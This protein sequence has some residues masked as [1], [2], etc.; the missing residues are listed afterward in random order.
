MHSMVLSSSRTIVQVGL[1]GES[2]QVPHF[3]PSTNSFT[4]EY[5]NN[6]TKSVLKSQSGETGKGQNPVLQ[7][8]EL[9]WP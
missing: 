2:P 4:Q 6:G 1:V 9:T 8:A 3:P 5:I 7:E